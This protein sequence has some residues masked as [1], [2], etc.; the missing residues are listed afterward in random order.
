MDATFKIV[1]R[2]CFNQLLIIYIKYFDEVFPIFF[3]LM[4][5]KTKKAYEGVFQYIKHNIFDMDPAVFITDYEHALRNS[6]RTVFPNARNVGCWFH[7]CQAIRRN[8]TSRK[9]L[10]QY[11]I[12]SNVAST[13]HNGQNGNFLEINLAFLNG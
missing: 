10:L 11:I 9:P 6:L 8:I 13:A 1:P 3:I 7:Y 5:K 4:D 12:S 2:G